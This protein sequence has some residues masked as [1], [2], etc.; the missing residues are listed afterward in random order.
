MGLLTA[1]SQNSSCCHLCTT[2]D[3]FLLHNDVMIA[4]IQ[5]ALTFHE[6]ISSAA[7]KIAL[8]AVKA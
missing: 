6:P 2:N 1:L 7:V 3:G 8:Q 5:A 4:S